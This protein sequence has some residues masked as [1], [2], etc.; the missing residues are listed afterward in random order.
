MWRKRAQE[1]R[2]R[3]DWA[4]TEIVGKRQKLMKQTD[5]E[6]L[7]PGS[8]VKVALGEGFKSVDVF[9]TSYG[10][11][12]IHHKAKQGWQQK[13]CKVLV[14]VCLG[15]SSKVNPLAVKKTPNNLFYLKLEIHSNLKFVRKVLE[16]HELGFVVRIKEQDKVILKH[17]AISLHYKR[18][19]RSSPPGSGKNYIPGADYDMP[20]YNQHKCCGGCWSGCSPVAWA[21]VFGYYDRRA[22]TSGSI[23]SPCI[24]GDSNIIWRQQHNMETA[25]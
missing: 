24:Y 4:M 16:S 20:D 12:G 3:L 15:E 25:T 11:H 10:N 6:A 19:L 9:V 5:E 23:F 13:L 7:S 21:Q 14:G 17:Y 8:V 18:L 2:T 22:S 1:R